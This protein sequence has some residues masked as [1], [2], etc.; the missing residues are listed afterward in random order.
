MP[1]AGSSPPRGREK[2]RRTTPIA[3]ASI[4]DGLAST[5]RRCEDRVPRFGDNHRM[6]CGRSFGLLLVLL[7]AGAVSATAASYEVA[8]LADLQARINAAVPGDVI[9]L[10]N[11]VYTTTAPITIDRKGAA[12][13]PI[14]I[15]AQTP[16]KVEIGGTGGFD[17]I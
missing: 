8:S 4:W 15:A 1:D 9:V 3:F 13:K 2:R 12:R 7:V 11:G 17:V 10:K 16:G 5:G 14:R 6:A